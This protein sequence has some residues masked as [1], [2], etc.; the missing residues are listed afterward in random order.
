VKQSII[1]RLPF[2]VIAVITLGL[3]VSPL[4][5]EV[6]LPDWN[7][8]QN[9][10]DWGSLEDADGNFPYATCDEG[11]SQSPINIKKVKRVSLDEIEFNY[12]PIELTLLNKGYT[13]EIVYESESESEPASTITVGDETYE[14]LQF[15]FHTKSEHT[16]HGDHTPVEMHLVHANEKG[17][18]AV[19]GVQI[20][21]GHRTNQAFE[22]IWDHLPAEE[23][24]AETFEG[25]F[26][27]A[28]DLLPEARVVEEDDDDDDDLRSVSDDDDGEGR[29]HRPYYTYDGSLTTPACN[30][31]VTWYLLKDFN[32]MSR[33]QIDE[34]RAIEATNDNYRLTQPLNDRTVRLFELSGDDDDD[35]GD[36][37]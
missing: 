20:K 30:E 4:Q 25:V 32:T 36:D 1:R 8:S 9:G 17:E 6:G 14:L 3:I 29:L 33:T 22:P 35:D 26:I 31:G 24:P 21:R 37:D 15:H 5:A 12:H 11:Q 13:I 2:L 16:R 19:V 34:L 23:G 10:E 7:H 18:L 27:N 28:Q